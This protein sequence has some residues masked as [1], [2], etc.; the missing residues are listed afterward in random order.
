MQ[1]A[2]FILIVLCLVGSADAGN[3]AQT[4]DPN[5]PST[6]TNQP[7]SQI[8]KSIEFEG[9]EKFKDHVLRERLGFELGER[10]DPFMAEGGR[11]T[12]EEVYRKVGYSSV[13]VS[14]DRTQLADGHLLYIIEEGPRVQ[15]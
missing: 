10:L 5:Q 13:K 4:A 9:N 6:I 1:D 3:A 2:T 11:L 14:L 15:I 8:I 12:I 7:S